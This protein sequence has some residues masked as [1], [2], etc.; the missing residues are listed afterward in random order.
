M[1][2]LALLLIVS[3][4]LP[5]PAA[6]RAEGP[7][8]VRVP[9]EGAVTLGAIL[10][11]GLDVVSARPGA[12]AEI[13]EWP[14]DAARLQALGARVSL[15]DAEPG[16]TAAERNRAQ[17]ALRHA[18]SARRVL[19][20][21][22]EDGVFRAVD[23]P[24]YG[25]GSLGGFWTLD[26]VK[27]KLDDLVAGDT[28][29]LVGDKLDTLGW[30]LQNRPV[31]GLL[32]GKHVSGPD[33]RPAVLLN[34]LTHAREPEGMETLFWFVDDLLANYDTDPVARYLLDQRR[35]YIVPVVNPDGYRYNQRIYDSTAVFGLWR[36]NLRDNDGNHVTNG[37]DGVDIN[38]NFGYQWGYDNIG[39]SNAQNSQTYRGTG[40]FSEP[41]TGIQRD[42]VAAL[43]PVTGFS[44]HT[45]GDLLVHPWGYVPAGTPDSVRF[46]TWTDEMSAVNGFTGGPGPRILYSVNGEFNDWTYGETVLKPRAFTWTPEI[47]GP[48]DD[49]WPPVDRIGT[50]A[51]SMVRSCYVV[52]GIAGPWVRA[53]AVTIAEG[54]L[55]AGH[56]AHLFVRAENIG[57]SG[58]AGPALQAQLTA[59]DHEVEV[60][61]GPVSFPSLGS[62]QSA[63]PAGAPASGAF[64]VAAA[65]TV[66]PGRSMRFRVDFT[67]ANA[68]HC[69]DTIEVVVGTPTTVFLSDCSAL[70][71][72]TGFGG[73]WGVKQNDPDHPSRYFTDSPAGLY[74]SG[75]N[76]AIGPTALL[77]LSHG[78]HAWALF[79]DRW[80]FES[81]YDGA[82]FEASRDG[83]DWTPLAAGATTLSDGANAVGDGL[84]AFEGS[85]WRW[86]GDRVDLSSFAGGGAN[87]QV[88]IRL[89]S[90][91][92]AGL[93]LD[94]L[95]VDSLRVLVYDPA[96][97]PAPVA[98]GP[99]APVPQLALAPPSP[100]PVRDLVRFGFD[101]P[102]AA[103]G[104]T[105]D[106][107]DVQGRRVVSY[108]EP[109]GRAGT[110]AGGAS[111]RWGW[112]L[113]DE[114]GR[115]VPAGLYLVRLRSG[116]GE[117]V[118]RIIVLP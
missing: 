97:Q 79:D 12:W 32:V 5:W 15:L 73:G 60:L 118:R 14:G 82:L 54:A 49:F 9:L 57:Q 33:T 28:R 61:S 66:T 99:P 40:A 10:E 59:L 43:Q 89:H 85:R 74:T 38:R 47:G 35:I 8:R 76:A 105:L 86:A 51:E 42:L 91:S 48:S 53:G 102:E 58:T 17:L 81:D 22:R 13:L 18:P 92:D 27:A 39:S 45:Y 7:R 16:R 109:A 93:Q 117:A 63:D 44:F 36:K 84:P 19:S 106:V 88:R 70:A 21:N 101:L 41:E 69:R 90:R 96:T 34:A 52:T 103:Q 29:D 62:F 67:D 72:W 11:S 114:D 3:V 80:V 1:R 2:R 116:A 65:D 30:T 26:E 110:A 115:R 87:A 6:A 68:M 55:N 95:S 111:Y 20:A 37:A 113:H 24:A 4:M 98:V 104:F 71:G 25:A 75:L 77:D 56:L 23:L 31:W 112:N 78:V 46:Q 107:L 100:N 108:A 83:I 50:L 64:V 94:G